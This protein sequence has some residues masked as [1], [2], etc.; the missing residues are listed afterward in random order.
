MKAATVISR[1]LGV[2]KGRCSLLQELGT[3]SSVSGGLPS[4]L[5][6]VLT[7]LEEDVSCHGNL[8]IH[9]EEEL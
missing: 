5:G 9:L 7:V 2:R 6:S 4:G 3:S 8:G 1:G